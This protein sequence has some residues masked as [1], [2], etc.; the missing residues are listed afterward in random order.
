MCCLHAIKSAFQVDV[1]CLLQ[2]VTV[3]RYLVFSLCL[4]ALAS[5]STPPQ[6]LDAIAQDYGFE[7]AVV[8]SERFEHTVF[9]NFTTT[10]ST[11][12]SVYLEG[13]GSP[14]VMRYIQLSDP[15]PRKPLMLNLMALDHQPALYLG[16]PCYNGFADAPEC[17]ARLWTSARYSSTVVRSMLSVLSAEIKRLGVTEVHIYGHSGGGTLAMLLAEHVPEVTRIVTLAGN[18]NTDG[19]TELHG[20]TPLYT[21]LNPI[22]RPA[23]SED[24]EQVHLVGQTDVNIPPRLVRAWIARQKNTTGVVL[25]GVNHTC[26]WKQLWPGVLDTLQSGPPYRWPGIPIRRLDDLDAKG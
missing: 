8:Q 20:Y 12:L 4:L 6:R 22:R 9:R 11:T 7:R 10:R 15:T 24:I 23:L 3:T 14:W 5:C 17:D 18:L 25:D 21:S 16:R 1:D 26:C 13:D 2:A 19:W